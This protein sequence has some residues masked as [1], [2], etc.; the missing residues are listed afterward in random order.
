MFERERGKLM[1][2]VMDSERGSRGK[3]STLGSQSI[4]RVR[5]GYN[6]RGGTSLLPRTEYLSA[7]DKG[8]ERRETGT[9]PVKKV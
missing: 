4:E 3:K 2:H 9:G 8:A 1:G 6:R 7:H 5:T